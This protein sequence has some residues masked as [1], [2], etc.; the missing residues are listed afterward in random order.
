[1]GTEKWTKC[2]SKRRSMSSGWVLFDIIWH[3]TVKTT[4]R[5][6]SLCE[7]HGAEYNQ[8]GLIREMVSV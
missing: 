5:P 3:A 1:M 4:N 2:S 8:D 7:K 6:I